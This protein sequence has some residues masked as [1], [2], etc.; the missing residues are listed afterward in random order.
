MSEDD[1]PT[2]PAPLEID[3]ASL[4]GDPLPALAD[5]L[6]DR[7]EAK[8]RGMEIAAPSQVVVP[9]RETLPIVGL[10][11]A[12]LREAKTARL[13]EQLL[14]VAMCVETRELRAAPAY[15]PRQVLREGPTSDDDPGEGMAGLRLHFD[16]FACLDLPREPATWL[17]QLILRDQVS[18]RVRVQLIGDPQRYRD[19]EVEAFL[20]GQESRHSPTRLVPPLT[21]AID[22]PL[23]AYGDDAREAP[24]VPERMGLCLDA[25]RV[26]VRAPG[27]PCVLRGSFRLPA[28]PRDTV[29]PEVWESE[30]R[31]RDALTP[32]I[33]DRREWA[34]P[35]PTA[36]QPVTLLTT[37]SDAAG[38]RITPLLL[39]SYD[40][41]DSETT[42]DA[43]TCGYTGRFAIDLI[44]RGALMHDA[45][46]CFIHAF[47]GEHCSEPVLV[48]VV[49]PDMLPD[50]HGR[51][52]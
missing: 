13:R 34:P 48:G 21:G 37:G 39:P 41:Y 35:I 49:T 19:A 25:P 51:G 46:T 12:T 31:R 7:L 17:I 4:W 50:R 44:E 45:Q 42:G 28:R 30:R 8:I 38:P 15:E 3:D 47:A 14:M 6:T 24:P 23:P 10:R 20:R 22:D 43:E 27:V 16:A 9:V 1:T 5:P 40:H 2:E 29:D 52:R 33:A 32:V 26:F 18:N 36:V 11:T